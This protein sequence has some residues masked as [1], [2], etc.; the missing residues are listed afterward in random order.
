M[1]VSGICFW[2]AWVRF[3]CIR[4]GCDYGVCAQRLAPGDIGPATWTWAEWMPGPVDPG[5]AHPGLDS[6][7]ASQQAIHSSHLVTASPNDVEQFG[8]CS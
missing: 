7:P 6:R 4:A 1:G 2:G 3:V 5:P 8:F